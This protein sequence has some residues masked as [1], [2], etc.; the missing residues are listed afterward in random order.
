MSLFSSIGK[1]LKSVFNA[2]KSVVLPAAGYAIGGPIGGAI[3]G[4]LSGPGKTSAPAVVSSSVLPPLAGGVAGAAVGGLA[5]LTSK[6]VIQAVDQFGRPV[7]RRRR[8][9]RGITATELKNHR[10]VETFLQKNF[11]CKSGGTRGTHIRRRAT[12]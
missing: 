6:N 1:G 3:G 11:K 8:R 5:A 4:L 7:V 12:R 2:A 9:R 10:R